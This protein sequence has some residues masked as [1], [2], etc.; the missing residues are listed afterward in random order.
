MLSEEK[1]E[2]IIA[3]DSTAQNSG[4]LSAAATPSTGKTFEDV[5]F[6]GSTNKIARTLFGFLDEKDRAKLSTP[7]VDARR[8]EH[9]DKALTNVD[10]KIELMSQILAA[11]EDN[12]Y[13]AQLSVSRNPSGFLRLNNDLIHLIKNPAILKEVLPDAAELRLNFWPGNLYKNL[14]AKLEPETGHSHPRGFTSFIVTGGYRHDIHFSSDNPNDPSFMV[15]KGIVGKKSKTFEKQKERHHLAPVLRETVA[16]ASEYAYFSTSMIHNVHERLPAKTGEM[17]HGTLSI[18]IVFDALKS[19]PTPEYNLY[20]NNEESLVEKYDQLEPKLA[21]ETLSIVQ[22][23]LRNKITEL[24]NSKKERASN[25]HATLFNHKELF[26]VSRSDSF[27]S[28]ISGLNDDE[29][30]VSD[31]ALPKL[32]QKERSRENED[33]VVDNGIAVGLTS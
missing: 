32:S 4:E 3:E 11:L 29:L 20:M 17:D 19:A 1:I 31:V 16:P 23:L 9:V 25:N 10:F 33:E 28:A 6:R 13:A 18:N 12:D 7:C 26:P 27:D 30:D 24:S 5:M 15:Y 22:G 14:G 21:Q 8:L 2:K